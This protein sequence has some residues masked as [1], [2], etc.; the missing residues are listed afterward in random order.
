[1][2]DWHYQGRY[3]CLFVCPFAWNNSAP[4][5]RISWKVKFEYFSKIYR[6]INFSLKALK[7]IGGTVYGHLWL[8]ILYSLFRASWYSIEIT[9]RWNCMQWILFLCLIHSTCFGRH[10]GPSSG[11]Q[12]QLSLQLPVQIIVSSQLPSFSVACR[13]RCKKVAETILRG[14]SRK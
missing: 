11:V 1:M 8:Y 6:E 2:V 3:V 10:T 14:L 7:N 12:F 13:P 4:T 9:N 5:G